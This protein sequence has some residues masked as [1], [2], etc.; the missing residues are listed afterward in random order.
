[1]RGF[2]NATDTAKFVSSGAVWGEGNKWEENLRQPQFHPLFMVGEEFSAETPT[3][4]LS[5]F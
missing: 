2:Q 4:C 3:L 1:M 5:L